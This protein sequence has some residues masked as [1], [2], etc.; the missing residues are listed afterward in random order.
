MITGLS[1]REPK[2][3]VQ[4]QIFSLFPSRIS[5][6]ESSSFTRCFTVEPLLPDTSCKRTVVPRKYTC[7]EGS[8]LGSGF[9]L[10]LRL[11]LRS[12]IRLD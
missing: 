10:G 1:Q 2:S 9:G 8:E 6:R 7:E 4:T 12:G 3:F 5:K 11:R